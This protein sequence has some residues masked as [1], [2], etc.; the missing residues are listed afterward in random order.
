MDSPGFQIIS[1]I[2]AEPEPLRS[3]LWAS[4]RLASAETAKMFP[5]ENETFFLA[6]I[7]VE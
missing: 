7:T 2:D 1:D 4:A 3:W 5:E 6:D